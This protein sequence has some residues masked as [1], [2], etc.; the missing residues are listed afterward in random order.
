M[1][2]RTLVSLF[3]EYWTYLITLRL[4][5]NRNTCLSLCVNFLH[6]WKLDTSLVSNIFTLN[7]WNNHRSVNMF[8][9]KV[10]LTRFKVKISHLF[11]H[12][13]TGSGRMI[14]TWICL[15]SKVGTL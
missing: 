2:K 14:S 15:D 4:G 12:F 11:S 3:H 1:A 9:V 8:I 10:I 13:C 6:T 7:S 5:H